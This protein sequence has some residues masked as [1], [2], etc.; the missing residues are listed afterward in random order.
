MFIYY[1]KPVLL[2]QSV[3][4]KTPH[5]CSISSQNYGQRLCIYRGVMKLTILV[6]YRK[7]KQ[8]T[9]NVL[10]TLFGSLIK[11]K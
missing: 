5:I 9:E 7:A 3:A 2:C 10:G 1:A 8:N 4:F 11:F 6:I